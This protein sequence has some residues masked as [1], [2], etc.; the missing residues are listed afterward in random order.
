MVEKS[1]QEII[2]F[3]KYKNLDYGNFVKKR[4]G[5]IQTDYKIEDKSLGQGG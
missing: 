2:P 1:S 3:E 4:H 5:S